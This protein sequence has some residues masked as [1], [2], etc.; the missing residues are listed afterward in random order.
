MLKWCKE[1]NAWIILMGDLIENDSKGSVGAGVYEQIMNPE[2]QKDE[3]IELLKP[4][5]HLILGALTGNHEERT[6]KD[7]GQDPTADICRSLEIPYLRYSAFLKLKVGTVN[8]VIYAT[9]GSGGSRLVS[10]KINCVMN[11]SRNFEADI[12]LMA[13]MHDLLTASDVYKRMNMHNH[14]I[15]DKKRYFIVTGSYLGYEN[16]YA[17]MMNLPPGKTGSPR[18]R[19]DGKTFDAHISL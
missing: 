3:V 9:H 6:F 17:E 15:E 16:S 8:Y 18:I 13:H 4:V 12:Y 2:Q 19:L 7:S 1:N 14:A 10:S 11:L 5:K